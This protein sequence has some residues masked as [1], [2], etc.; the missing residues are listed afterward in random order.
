MSSADRNAGGGIVPGTDSFVVES[1]AAFSRQSALWL[2]LLGGVLFVALLW[3]IGNGLAAGSTNNGGGHAGG[4]GLNGFAAWS[5]YLKRRGLD[6][7]HARTTAG[8]RRPGLLVLTPPADIDGAEIDAIVAARRE[9]GPTMVIAPKWNAAV[10][11]RGDSDARSGWVRLAG[12]RG[13]QW[14]GFLDDVTVEMGPAVTRGQ[15][16]QWLARR[17]EGRF[18]EPKVTTWGEGDDL[19]PL[20][21][22]PDGQRIYA[23]FL[24]D[25]SYPALAAQAPA[26]WPLRGDGERQELYPLILVFDPD[27]LDNY[28]LAQSGNAKLGEALVRAAMPGGSLGGGPVTFDLTLNGLGYSPNLLTLAFTPPFLA[29]TLCL[30]LA[31]AA[32]GWRAFFRF[33]PPIAGERPISFGKRALVINT[34]GLVRRAGRLHLLGAPYADAAR[35]RLAAALGVS[36]RADAAAQTLAIDR[37]AA[38]AGA[39]DQGFSRIAARLAEARS[40]RDLLKAAQELHA[41][42]RT[43]RR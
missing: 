21:L 27:L 35:R 6:V 25:G 41:L 9:I 10:A 22:S 11:P 36:R 26:G 40:A 2:V 3:M 15:G 5:E 28:G 4:R 18:P 37:A 17:I 7:Q 16:A 32:A 14:P 43:L 12:T 8:L 19:V 23:A 24:S 30:L 29:A 1:T 33:G 38:M 13:P 31:I 42:E 39:G 34:A 20:V